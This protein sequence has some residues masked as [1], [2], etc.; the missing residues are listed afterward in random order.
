VHFHTHGFVGSGQAFG[1]YAV[2]VL[3]VDLH[4]EDSEIEMDGSVG[5]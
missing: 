5:V 4:F 3:V 1:G 2:V